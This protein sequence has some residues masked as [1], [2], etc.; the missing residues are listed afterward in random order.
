M[1]LVLPGVQTALTQALAWQYWPDGQ[2]V[3]ETQRTQ[4]P[5]VMS[6]SS[7]SGVQVR[8]DAHLVRHM[9]ATQVLVVS[10]QSASVRQATQRPTVVSQTWD[11]MQSSEFAHGVNAMQLR[12]TQSLFV[13]QSA[14]LTHSTHWAMAG[15]HTLPL[16][17]QS[18]LFWQL[19][20]MPPSGEFRPG[21]PPQLIGAAA[22]ANTTPN[23]KRPTRERRPRARPKEMTS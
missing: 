9:S 7:P 22:T 4:D 14:A 18:R 23:K 21:P 10:M 16:A 6:H 8:S 1:Q 20:G 12:A 19:G 3:E 11:D 13:G 5:L 17:A 2:S 15:S